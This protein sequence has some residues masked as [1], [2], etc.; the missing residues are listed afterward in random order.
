MRKAATRLAELRAQVILVARTYAF[1][2]DK[3]GAQHWLDKA[4]EDGD[5]TM[6]YLKV[7]PSF[8]ILR[9][10][11]RFQQLLRKMKLPV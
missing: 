5:S 4:Y 6:V 7:D 11:A 3:D 8:E 10:D 9:E 2:G 1:A